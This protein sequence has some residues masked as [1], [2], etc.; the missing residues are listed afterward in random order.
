[1][2]FLTLNTQMNVHNILW[3]S[4]I[5]SYHTKSS[6]EGRLTI[7]EK[8]YFD[9]LFHSSVKIKRIFFEIFCI[10][11]VRGA[12]FEVMTCAFF[13][14]KIHVLIWKVEYTLN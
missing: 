8:L 13:F 11:F 14:N 6:N 5:G 7:S 9:N 2:V 4:V 3:L 1:M 10:S 12:F